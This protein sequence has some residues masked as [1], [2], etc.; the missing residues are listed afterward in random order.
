MDHVK[1]VVTSTFGLEAVIKRE[2]Q[3]LGFDKFSVVDGRIE[4]DALVADIPRLNIHLRSADRVLVKLGEFPAMDFGELFDRTKELPWEE[5]I[6]PDAKLTVVGKCVRSQLESVRSSQSIAHKA[7]IERLKS[8]FNI[9]WLSGTGPEYTIQVAILKDVAHLTLDTSGAGLHKRGYR[10][11]TGEVP[12]RENL[13][14]AMVQLTF[15]KKDR[16]LM[17]PMCG[18]GT[19]LIEAAMIARNMAPGLKRVFDAEHWPVVKRSFWDD[20]RAK[21]VAMILPSGGLKILG[22]D[23][24]P[25]RIKDARANAKKAGVADDITFECKDINDLWI[26]EAHG[27]V[28]SNPPYGVKLG[29]L[30]ELTPIYIT[31]HNMFKN[32]PG[33]SLYILTADGRFPDF[34]KRA[35]PDRVRKLFNGT[36]EVN[37][38]QYHGERPRE[39]QVVA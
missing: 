36:I 8:K 16:L 23:I 27:I 38:Y 28:I 21:A 25:E 22:Y 2:L 26:H 11:S 19:I 35:K 15:W 18:S 29:S 32:K 10:V 34:F 7:V 3:D 6:T 31:I 4:F 17:D 33:W 12:I 14:A 37:Y 9:D 30:K 13:A 20:A 39:G 5:W 24:D 1:L